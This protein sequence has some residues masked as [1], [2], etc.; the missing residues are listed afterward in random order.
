MGDTGKAK[1]FDAIDYELDEKDLVGGFLE[2]RSWYES[3]RV[4]SA[5]DEGISKLLKTLPAHKLVI[6]DAVPLPTGIHTK[7]VWL[8]KLRDIIEDE[9][10]WHDNGD[11]M[12]K[13]RSYRR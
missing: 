10:H 2:E 3:S 8:R 1:N 4:D 5:A 13:S 11:V 7:I 9:L 12:K 6:M